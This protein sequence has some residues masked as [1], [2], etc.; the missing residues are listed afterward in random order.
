MKIVGLNQIKD[1][2][3]NIHVLSFLLK[4]VHDHKNIVSC[5]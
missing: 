5:P 3:E 1:P 4:N 2:T